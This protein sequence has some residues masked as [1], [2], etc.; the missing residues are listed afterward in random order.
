MKK[1]IIV[2]GFTALGKTTLGKK[3][4]NV[5]DLESSLYQ[6]KYEDEMTLEQI[7]N[8]KGKEGRI[9]NDEFPLNYFNAIL[10]AQ[11]EYDVILTS[12]H[13]ELLEEFE[14]NGI[15]YY[16]AYPELDFADA[17]RQRCIHR[18][19]SEEWSEKIKQKVLDWYPRLKD[20][21]PNEILFVSKDKYLEDVL[22]KKGILN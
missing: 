8:N 13:W 5:I 9:Y 16:L 1:G 22:K 4:N 10:D 7:E 20:Y 3:Y 18:G 19:N 15:E 6:W 14:K 17:I 21:K 2:A 12:M 11:K